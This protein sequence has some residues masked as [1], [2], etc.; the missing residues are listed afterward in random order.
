MITDRDFE[1]LCLVVLMF[2][3]SIFGAALDLPVCLIHG[4]TGIANVAAA[5]KIT[6]YFLP[7]LEQ[8]RRPKGRPQ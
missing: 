3:W 4:G 8:I 1:I 2:A 5:A 6:L 7:R